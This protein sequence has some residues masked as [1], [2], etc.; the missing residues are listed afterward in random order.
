M[1]QGERG[2][3]DGATSD[4][5]VSPNPGLSGEVGGGHA[6]APLGHGGQSTS[7]PAPTLLFT[8]EDQGPTVRLT[9]SLKHTSAPNKLGPLDGSSPRGT[10]FSGFRPRPRRAM[11]PAMGG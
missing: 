8:H 1:I 4:G 5:L 7:P 3:P 6:V 11:A 2:S 9:G 10:W